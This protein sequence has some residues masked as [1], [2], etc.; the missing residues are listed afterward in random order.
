MSR[1][2]SSR[3]Q[4]AN[5]PLRS[6]GKIDV[7][8]P[9]CAQQFRIAPE[10]LDAKITCTQCTRVFFAR[11]TAGKRPRPKDYTKIYFAI[12]AG[13]LLVIISIVLLKKGPEP[14]KPPEPA[15]SH[16]GK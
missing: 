2:V 11:T 6:D 10:N 9:N 4:S 15:K 5:V 3:A 1:R 8:C 14:Q 16:G 13:V 7:F 12:A